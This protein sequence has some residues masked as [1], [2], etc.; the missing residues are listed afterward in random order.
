MKG[1]GPTNPM[2][3]QKTCPVLDEPFNKLPIFHT[4]YLML[5]GRVIL[6]A[7][8]QIIVKGHLLWFLSAY[9]LQIFEK[10]QLTLCSALKM[11]LQFN[12]Y[13]LQRYKKFKISHQRRK[14]RDTNELGR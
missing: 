7:F 8:L 11:H 3:L 1:L 2:N 10:G 9:I 13:K 4:K 12:K 6:N 14:K 5:F